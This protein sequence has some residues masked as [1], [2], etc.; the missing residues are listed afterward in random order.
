MDNDCRN[1]IDMDG[2]IYYPTFYSYTFFHKT[3]G[4]V[5]AKPGGIFFVAIWRLFIFSTFF[6]FRNTE[7]PYH[8]LLFR[9]IIGNHK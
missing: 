3:I 1:L 7:G 8:H 4:W 5:S 9:V 6:S 2:E